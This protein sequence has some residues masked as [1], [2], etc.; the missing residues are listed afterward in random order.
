MAELI[1]RAAGL[2]V[3]GIDLLTPDISRPFHAVPCAI[4]EINTQPGLGPF[5]MPGRENAA[6]VEAMVDLLFPDGDPGPI[7][8]QQAGQLDRERREGGQ[9]AAEADADEMAHVVAPGSQR[10]PSRAQPATLTS[11]V[12]H[13]KAPWSVAA[14]IAQRTIAPVVPPAATSR[15]A[16]RSIRRT[17]PTVDPA[18]G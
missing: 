4:T 3:V 2:D 7:V 5:T 6:V 13:G 18:G 15:A 16:R 9:P 1:A 8:A 17:L 12:G 14:A 11:R 10:R